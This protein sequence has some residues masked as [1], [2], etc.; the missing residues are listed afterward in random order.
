MNGPAMSGNFKNVIGR[1]VIVT[2]GAT[3]TV[4]LDELADRS[5]KTGQ[6]AGTEGRN[7]PARGTLTGIHQPSTFAF[8]S[9]PPPSAISSRDNHGIE[10]PVAN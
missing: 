9:G 8:E 5:S 1:A 10:W 6:S 2:K 4:A 7:C 3:L